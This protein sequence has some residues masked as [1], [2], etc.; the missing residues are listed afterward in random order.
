METNARGVIGA[1]RNVRFVKRPHSTRLRAFLVALVSVRFACAGRSDAQG[2]PGA[3]EPEALATMKTF[4]GAT[5]AHDQYGTLSPDGLWFAYVVRDSSLSADK[6]HNEDAWYT[7]TG[8]RRLSAGTTLQIT[9]TRTGVTES[10]TTGPGLVDEPA[11]SPNGKLLA[12][13]ADRD[14]Q[15]R[16]WVWNRATGTL[17][18]VSEVVI[19]P[20]PFPR[21]SWSPN[22]LA[23]AVTLHSDA[24]RPGALVPVKE[25][26]SLVEHSHTPGASV[27]VFHSHEEPGKDDLRSSADL[28]PGAP[29]ASRLNNQ[30][31]TDP[32]GADMAI[33]GLDG[34]VRRLGH[35]Q[36]IFWFRFSPNG[37]SLAFSSV[38]GIYFGTA[39]RVCD[40]EIASTSEGSARTLAKQV[41][42]DYC[43]GSWSPDSSSIAYVTNGPVANGDVHVINAHSGSDRNLTPNVHPKLRSYDPWYPYWSGDGRLLYLAG[44]GRLWAISAQG[45]GITALTPDRWSREV[46]D[47]VRDAATNSVWTCDRDRSLTLVTRNPETKETGLFRLNTTTGRLT[48]LREEPR[49]LA[50]PRTPPIA[51]SSA[52]TLL[53]LAEDARNPPDA[54]VTDCGAKAA[55]RVTTLNSQLLGLTFGKASVVNFLGTSGQRLHAALILPPHYRRGLRYPLIVDVY[56]GPYVESD[57]AY[58][59]GTGTLSLINSQ[60]LATR[61]YAVLVP[62][63]PISTSAMPMEDIVQ[64][65]E[66][67]TNRIIELGIADPERLGIVGFSAG[68]Y[69]TLAVITLTSRFKA[70]IMYAGIGDLISKY[71][72]FDPVVQ[73]DGIPWVES[74]LESTVWQD[75]LRFQ[76]NSPIMYLDRVHTPLLIVHG[77]DDGNVPVALGDQVFVGL[78]R[79]NR[80]V[81]Y[82]RY[83]GEDHPLLASENRIDYWRSVIR[84]FDKYVKGSAN[85]G[86]VT[87]E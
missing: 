25:G 67:A 83:A 4:A 38:S 57:H 20:L 26:D 45:G 69:S 14:G 19:N 12:F 62:D 80:E 8:M 77:E 23:I 84:W 39:Q 13:Y 51:A 35:D 72:S 74:L 63:T 42:A 5:F 70:A 27:R 79:L 41:S 76:Q 7:P 28:A 32:V 56:P 52:N 87:K 73:S 29:N 18:R 68:G 46:T 22:S 59:F 34:A 1:P 71:L 44:A 10:L 36:D 17:R 65:I 78:R 49:I 86:M 75:P 21:L 15:P 2:S 85:E 60:L 82:R 11:W 53:Y 50:G 40:Y 33:V 31:R 6:A 55:R 61:G 64:C 37:R 16:L 24:P 43:M 48:L 66:L 58:S 54:W 30:Y 3:L 81:E 9:N 47:I